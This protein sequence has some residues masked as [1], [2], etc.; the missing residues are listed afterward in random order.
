MN[1][2]CLSPGLRRGKETAGAR[3]FEK[4]N[5]S[6]SVECGHLTLDGGKGWEASGKETQTPPVAPQCPPPHHV[7]FCLAAAHS[8]EWGLP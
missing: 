3:D 8:D 2:G 1:P 5:G 6:P 7:H 4:P